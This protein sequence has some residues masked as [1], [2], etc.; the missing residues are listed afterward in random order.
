[1]TTI[2]RCSLFSI[3]STLASST[4][5]PHFFLSLAVRLL[6]RFNFMISLCRLTCLILRFNVSTTHYVMVI[7]VDHDMVQ[8]VAVRNSNGLA[9]VGQCVYLTLLLVE[10]RSRIIIGSVFPFSQ[11][12]V[13]ITLIAP[14]SRSLHCRVSPSHFSPLSSSSPSSQGD[15]NATAPILVTPVSERSLTRINVGTI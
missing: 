15:F 12:V 5:L 3:P 10:G 11:T 7:D 13:H 9:L 4:C 2:D 8:T 1:M 14:P 6:I